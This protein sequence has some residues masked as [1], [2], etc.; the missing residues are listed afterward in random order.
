[1]TFRRAD[2]HGELDRRLR[3]FPG[4]RPCTDAAHLFVGFKWMPMRRAGWQID[5][6][7]TPKRTMGAS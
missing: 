2:S 5:K 4:C 7:V 3:N 6:F 1:M